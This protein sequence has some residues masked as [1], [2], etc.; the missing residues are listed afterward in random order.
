M[1]LTM[2][3]SQDKVAEDEYSDELK[4]LNQTREILPQAIQ[5]PLEEIEEKLSL[6]DSPFLDVNKLTELRFTI[7][8]SMLEIQNMDKKVHE[9]LRK[10][11]LKAELLQEYKESRAFSDKVK[12]LLKRASKREA[13]GSVPS[14]GQVRS[15]GLGLGSTNGQGQRSW[16][17][18]PSVD[19]PHSCPP[20]LFPNFGYQ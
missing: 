18:H 20:Q 17:S 10:L 16:G 12:M 2:D 5:E 13:Q 1:S 4:E 6:T 11:N 19:S 15:V 8:P 7:E 9:I 3:E 14:T